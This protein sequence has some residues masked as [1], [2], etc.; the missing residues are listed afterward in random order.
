MKDS[1]VKIK[2][3]A[4]ANKVSSEMAKAKRAVDDNARAMASSMDRVRSSFEGAA[5]GLKAFVSVLAIGAA[6]RA[7][8]QSVIAQEQAV[9]QLNAVL[10]STGRMTPELSQKLQDYATSLQKVSTYGDETVVAMQALLLTFTR[11]GGDEF[12]RAQQAVLDVATALHVDLK[13]AALQVGKALNDPILG[14]TAL[15][16]SGIQFSD[17]QKAMVKQLMATGDIVSAQKII[18]SELE[19]QFGGSAAAARNTLGGALAALKNA[20]DDLLEGNGGGGGITGTTSALN[21]LTGILQDPQTVQSAQTLTNALITGFGKVLTAISETVEFTKWLSEELAARAYGVANDDIIRLEMNLDKAKSKVKE[22]E[23]AY[24]SVKWAD[25]LLGKVG[26]SEGFLDQIRGIKTAREEVAKLQKQVDEY[27]KKSSPKKSPGKPSPPDVPALGGGVV[28]VDEEAI[29]KATA[30]AERRKKEGETAILNLERELA[31]LGEKTGAEKILWEIEKGK[32][33]DLDPAHKARIEQLAREVDEKK[34]LV[35]ASEDA[36]EQMKKEVE[37]GTKASEAGID[38][39]I[40]SAKRITE[41][42]RTPME[43][44]ADTIRE[45]NEL[46][47]LGLINQETYSRA[48]KAALDEMNTDVKKTEDGFKELQKAIEGWGQQSA[49]AIVDFCLT[50]KASFSDMIESMIAD[51]LKMMIY[52]NITGPIAG[53][54][55]SGIKGLFTP[56]AHGNVFSDGMIIPHA[57]GGVVTRPTLFP[58]ARGMGLMGEAGAE[59]VMPLRRMP[60]GDLGVAATGGGNNVEINVINNAGAE[61]STKTKEANGGLQID[62]MIDQAVAK[63]MGQFGSSSNK[64]LRQNYNAREKLVQR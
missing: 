3:T 12:N 15:A 1:E 52:Q 48:A 44:Y 5:A 13:T 49:Q 62:V 33:A 10:K 2:I 22:L 6:F 14:M 51:L 41:Q 55:S 53:A 56:N 58:M 57:K 9:A 25:K 64:M 60:G 40:E 34:K 24:N 35:K 42:A 29:K 61:V 17:S 54:I 39:L 7:I 63:K 26:I 38:K 59:A 36:L 16:R 21:E 19:T 50:G 47:S 46:L 23:D 4:D 11:I 43:V 31:L 28:V 45:I 8:S 27:W 37:E 32:Y 18:L 20:F 30:E